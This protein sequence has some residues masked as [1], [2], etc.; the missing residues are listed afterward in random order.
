MGLIK[1]RELKRRV[2]RGRKGRKR[3]GIGKE[4]E[5]STYNCRQ[6]FTYEMEG[7]Y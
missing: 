5:G 7:D 1:T 6:V 2:G 3:K 4:I